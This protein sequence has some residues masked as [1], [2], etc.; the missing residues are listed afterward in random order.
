[1]LL[2][3]IDLTFLDLIRG[4]EVT[5]GDRRW[6]AWPCGTIDMIVALAGQTD[7]GFRLVNPFFSDSLAR[8]G[9][10]RSSHPSQARFGVFR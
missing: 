4:P 6:E 9:T 5:C 8:T 10:A 3:A 2:Y 7:A 1:M